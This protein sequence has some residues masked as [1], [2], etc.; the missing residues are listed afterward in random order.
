MCTISLYKITGSHVQRLPV[1]VHMYTMYY[2]SVVLVLHK[3]V[4]C[5]CSYRVKGGGSYRKYEENQRYLVF[6][7]NFDPCSKTKNSIFE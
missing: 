7:R 4:V 2:L 3:D 6:L 1:H 5:L